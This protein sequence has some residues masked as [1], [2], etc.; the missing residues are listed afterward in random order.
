MQRGGR[1]ARLRYYYI[2]VLILLCIYACILLYMCHH[3][4][5]HVSAGC[6]LRLGK[7][8]KI[9]FRRMLTY[10]DVYLLTYAD[11]LYI[12]VRRCLAAPWQDY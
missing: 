10:A 9:I 6:S 12:C 3:T 2:C 5:I 7:T 4:A 11:V 8:N 1:V